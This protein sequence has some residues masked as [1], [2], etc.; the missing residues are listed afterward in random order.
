MAG[1]VTVFGGGGF[2]GRYVAQALLARGARV[3]I[4]SRDPRSAWFLKPLGNLGQTEFV[5]ADIRRA[6]SVERAVIGSDAVVNLVGVLTGDFHAMHVAGA[7]HIARAAAAARAGAL[8][9]VS[10]IGA[11]PASPSAYGRSKGEGELGVRELFPAATIVRPSILF[12]PEDNFVNKFAGMAAALPMVPVLKGDARFQP[13]WVADVAQT[14][15]IAALEPGRHGGRTYELG[16]P[17]VLTMAGLNRWVAGA[18]GRTPR[19]IE[20]PDAIGGAMA[21]LG[22]LPGAP[23]TKDQWAMLQRDNVV[24]PGAEGFAAFGIDPTPLAA[25]APQWLVRYRR[26]GRFGRDATAA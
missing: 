12:G 26:Q 2:L 22:F 24:A 17:E 23:I 11:D 19:I 25:V 5:A 3:R 4:V 13:A 21:A 1:L 10:A 18:I 6:A 20:L 9:H 8:V 16:G 15:A 7:A 14:I